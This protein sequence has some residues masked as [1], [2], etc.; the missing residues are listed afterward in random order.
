MVGR[1]SE[2]MGGAAT[3]GRPIAKRHGLRRRTER[4]L[5]VIPYASVGITNVARNIGIDRLESGL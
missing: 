1:I 4:H 3:E 2:A 5:S